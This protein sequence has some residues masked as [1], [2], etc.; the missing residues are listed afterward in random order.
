MIIS[1]ILLIFSFLFEGFISNY[2]SSSLN[3]LNLFTTLYTLVTLVVIYPY[4]NNEKK[5]YILLL[6]FAF[7]IDVAY[8]NTLILNII[9]FFSISL[10][11]K[12]LNFILPENILVMN[13]ISLCSVV[14]YHVFSYIVLE[15][16]NYNSYPISLLFDICLNSI[17]MTI[18]Y[19]TLLY[20]ITKYLYNKFDI[21]QIK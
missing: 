14:L 20:V 17:I 3:D 13:I 12:F 1:I 6:I 15:I 18:I 21:K 8:T 4:F 11:V 7:L 5:Y 10:V 2:I 16:V 19:T 9:L